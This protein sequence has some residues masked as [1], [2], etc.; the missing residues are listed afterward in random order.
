MRPRPAAVVAVLAAALMVSCGLPPEGTARAVPAEEVPYGLL[1]SPPPPEPTS[2]AQGPGTTSPQLYLLDDDDQLVPTPL[3]VEAS[4]LRPVVRQLLDQLSDG[5]TEAQR[6]SGLASALGPDV[7]LSLDA[8]SGGTA[9]VEVSLAVRQ[10]TAD[11][12]PL[13]VGQVVLTLTSVEG[14]DRVL[15]VQ[16][17]EPTEMALPGG[18]RT[19][20]PVGA[21]QY[22]ALVAPDEQP[23]P[24]AEPTPTA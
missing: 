15:L 8:I 19:S 10:P 18:A 5:P 7:N 20:A 21:A 24:K 4:G 14:V 22:L 11:R 16:D 23:A 1:N 9:R 3:T 13:A 12:L 17:G 2:T 6:D